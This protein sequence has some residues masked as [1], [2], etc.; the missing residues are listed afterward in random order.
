MAGCL[1]P[2][3]NEMMVLYHDHEWCVPSH[4]DAYLFEMLILEGAQAGL[5]WNTVLA[6]REEYRKAFHNFDLSYCAGLTDEEIETI[7][8]RYNV[9]KNGLKLRSVRNN[10]LAI[11]KLKKEYGSFSKFLWGY[12]D[13]KPI[14]NNW[15]CDEQMPAK[16]ELSE[17]ISKDLKKRGF[18]FV[19]PV[20]IYSF[21]QAVGIVD[22]HI[23]TC[24]FHTWNR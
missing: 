6:K 10:A 14:I 17:R 8:E 21:L 3:K 16:S 7:R 5:S 22:D 13:D 24:P 11:I 9:I 4:D 15:D 18:Q 20:I 19:G 23:R 2:G 1:W 12:V